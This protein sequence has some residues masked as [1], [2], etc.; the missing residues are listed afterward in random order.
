MLKLKQ[1][2]ESARVLGNASNFG[3]A[4]GQP[5]P[6]NDAGQGSKVGVQLLA[7]EQSI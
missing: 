2:W 5:Q 7:T 4:P 1:K 3:S 6:R